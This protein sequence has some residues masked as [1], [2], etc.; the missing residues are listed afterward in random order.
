MNKNSLFWL[1]LFVVFIIFS[2]KSLVLPGYFPIHDELQAGRLYQM[3]LC[4]RDGQIPCRWVPDMG[5][6]YGYPLFNFYP[7]LPFYVG[8]IFHLAGLGYLDS[9]KIIFILGLIFSGLF[10]Y[11]LGKELWGGYGGLV[12]GIFYLYAPYHAVDVYVRGA[13]NEFWGLVFIPAIFWS[14]LKI[15]KE[16]KRWHYV[17][18]AIFFACL[19]LSH[20]LIAFFVFPAVLVWF[21]F[22]VWY[23]RKPFKGIFFFTASL[24]WGIGLAAFFSFPVIFEQKYVHIESMFTDYFNYQ[25]HFATVNQLFLSRFWG[26]GPSRWGPE[27]G[28]AFP[29]GQIHW[30]TGVIALIIFAFLRLRSKKREI[31]LVGHFFLLFLGY[32]FLAHQRSY[33]IWQIIPILA[34]VQ[35]PWRFVGLSS[36]FVTVLSGSFF[37]LIKDERKAQVLVALMIAGVFLFNFSFFQPERIIQV[38]DKEKLFSSSGWRKLQSDAINDYLPIY[39]K[40]TPTTSAPSLPIFIKE[41]GDILNFKKGTDW[42]EF[43]AI[44]TPK[45]M[46][47]LPLYYFP[48][49]K[50]WVNGNEVKT[51]YDNLFGLITFE[52]FE[53]KNIIKV[54]L[55]N[56]PVRQISNIVSLVSWLLLL[57]CFA[58]K[59]KSFINKQALGMLKLR[60]GNKSGN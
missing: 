20:N 38:S 6:G 31:L 51:S 24:I 32:A 45:A 21:L 46:V 30:L 2:F 14:V 42:E 26:F 56:T 12:V 44:T 4:I 40:V 49:M 29:I 18:N 48:G 52:L 8:E 19:L 35:F 23:F 58:V 25:G 10:A 43:T 37:L 53:N 17:F 55:T 60:G 33:Q 7:P 16:G 9:V 1:L 47:Q 13:V 59:A 22:L 3:D 11:L 54:K 15:A 50:V 28:L 36:F 5:Y 34:T 27:D 39:A 41:S 57:G